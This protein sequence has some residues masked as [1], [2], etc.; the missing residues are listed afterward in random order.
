MSLARQKAEQTAYYRQQADVIAD[1]LLDGL[2]R[3]RYKVICME[4]FSVKVTLYHYVKEIDGHWFRSPIVQE[5]LRRKDPSIRPSSL[6]VN[7]APIGNLCLPLSLSVFLATRNRIEITMVLNLPPHLS[8][9]WVRVAP[10]GHS[11]PSP[12]SL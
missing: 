12:G 4:R 11:P 8:G 7:H 3:G 9:Q 2:L 1:R 5:A 6:A 10:P